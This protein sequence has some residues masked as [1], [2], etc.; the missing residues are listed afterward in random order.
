[1]YRGLATSSDSA[2]TVGPHH[3]PKHSDQGCQ[4][5]PTVSQNPPTVSQ[6]PVVQQSP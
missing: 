5:L 3:D 4:G 2:H 6:N 1:M